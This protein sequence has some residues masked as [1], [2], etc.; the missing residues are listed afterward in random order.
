M[1]IG[2]AVIKVVNDF[3]NIILKASCSEGERQGNNRPNRYN[4][5][6]RLL[7]LDKI[8]Q[9]NSAGVNSKDGADKNKM[10]QTA[11]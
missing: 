5:D 9:G 10:D 11:S 3:L 1:I 6:V 2:I 8:K 7:V 4:T